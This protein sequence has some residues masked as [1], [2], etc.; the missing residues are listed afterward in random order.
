GPD[1]VSLEVIWARFPPRDP[2]LNE[3]VWSHIDETQIDPAAHRE[4]ARNGFRAGI[5]SGT[6]PDAIARALNIAA[7]RP[8]TEDLD[9]DSGSNPAELMNDPTVQRRML[10]VQAGRRAEIQASDVLDSVPLLLARGRELGGRT[11]N[12]AQAIYALRVDPQP[13]QTVNV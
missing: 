6:P 8:R 2:D 5:I 10:Q 4:L 1:S 3:S 13:N 7:Y 12:N 9:S 11:F